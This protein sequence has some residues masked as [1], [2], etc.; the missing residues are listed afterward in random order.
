[1]EKRIVWLHGMLLF[2]LTILMVRLSVLGQGESLAQAAT[3]R[4]SPW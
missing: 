1:M 3:G 2:C 4:E